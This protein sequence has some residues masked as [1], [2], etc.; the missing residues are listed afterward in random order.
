MTK[1]ILLDVA[2]SSGIPCDGWTDDQC[3]PTTPLE[4]YDRHDD[5]GRTHT[6]RITCIDW[7]ESIKRVRIY[8]LHQGRMDPRRPDVDIWTEGPQ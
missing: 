1:S 5:H 7:N 8:A 2:T 3:L 6:A 4:I